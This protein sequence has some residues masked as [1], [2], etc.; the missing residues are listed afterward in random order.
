MEL[1][2]SRE[3]GYVLANASGLIDDSA[4]DLFRE[5]LHPLVGQRGTKLVLELSLAKR[6]N[7]AGLS[8]L[9][10]LVTNANTHGSRVVLAACSSFVS[11]VLSRSK[12][13]QFFE[14]A[15][16]VPEAIERVLDSNL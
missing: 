3:E 8:H 11:V 14:I 13:D 15:E 7:S 6:V 16:T 5:H 4:G 1:R 2:V 10:M 12:L 9:V